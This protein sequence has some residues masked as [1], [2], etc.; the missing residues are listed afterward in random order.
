MLTRMRCWT[1]VALV[2][3]ALC[4]AVASAARR[5]VATKVLSDAG[6]IAPGKDGGFSQ[7]CPK[8]FPHPVG[9]EFNG[10]NDH[11]A[12]DETFTLAHRR[13]NQGF[14]NFGDASE[15]FFAGPVCLRAPGRFAYPEKAGAVPAGGT[16]AV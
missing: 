1:L 10:A 2:L 7:R 3:A 12:L 16:A 14:R 9:T 8:A 4:P 6:Q 11:I 15:T 13:W 5:K